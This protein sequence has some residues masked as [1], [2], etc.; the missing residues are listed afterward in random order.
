MRKV[1]DFMNEIGLANIYR[2]FH[3]N[4]KEYTLFLALHGFFS[5]INHILGHKQVTKDMKKL[6]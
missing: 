6:K 5:K 3:P 1:T 2:I 4:T